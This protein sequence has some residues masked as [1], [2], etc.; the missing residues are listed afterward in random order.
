MRPVVDSGTKDT[1]ARYL[2]GT[3][4]HGTMHVEQGN[5]LKDFQMSQST[6][7]KR[8]SNWDRQHEDSVCFEIGTM[9]KGV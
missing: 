7:L 6:S 2:V 4:N 9:T 1:L 3:N 5:N 8:E